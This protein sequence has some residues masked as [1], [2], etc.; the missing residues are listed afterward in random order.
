MFHAFTLETDYGAGEHGS[1]TSW[2][3]DGWIGGDYHKLAVKSEGEITE[4]ETEA[5]EFW[6]MYSRN[7]ATFWDAQFGLRHDTQPESTSYAVLGVE[8]LAPQ[9]FETEVSQHDQRQRGSHIQPRK[10]QC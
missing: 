6:G 7:I 1:V 10:R 9:F 4:S 2:D 3:L 5:A 8:G